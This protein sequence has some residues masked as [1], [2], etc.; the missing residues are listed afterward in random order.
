MRFGRTTTL[1]AG[2]AA[3]MA[4]AATAHASIIPIGSSYTLIATNAPDT[5][6]AN[7]TFGGTVLLDGGAVQL[8]M[9]QIATGANGEWDVWT[10]TTTNGGP[11]AGNINA[12]WDIS[13]DYVLSQNV[14]FDGVLDQWTVNG[15]PVSPVTN[16]GSICC[17]VTNNPVTGGAGYYNSGF[18]DPI[19]A[20]TFDNW[21]Q[22][23]VSPYS[24][25]TAGGIDPTTANG[26]TWALHFTLQNPVATPEPGDFAVFG[27]GLAGLGL[28]LRRRARRAR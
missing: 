26:F 5:F 28:V 14:Y 24:F 21:D 2:V 22:I 19:S 1:G 23:Y 25:V 16:F 4:V 15:T 9:S 10:L 6:T 27:M 17:A 18:Q 12:Y 11:I 20:G 8:S 13:Q 3:L 7:T